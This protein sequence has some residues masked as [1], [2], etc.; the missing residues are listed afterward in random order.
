MADISGKF[1]RAQV[2]YTTGA[3]VASFET[4][5]SRE[6]ASAIKIDAITSGRGAGRLKINGCRPVGEV[7]T[8]LRVGLSGQVFDRTCR[9]S[10]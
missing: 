10:T 2:Y 6:R 1:A 4:T 5:D 3:E 7:R 9:E 8:G